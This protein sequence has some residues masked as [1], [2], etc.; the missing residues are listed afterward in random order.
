MKKKLQLLLTCAFCAAFWLAQSQNNTFRVQFSVVDATCYN[1]GK[2][3][4]GLENDAGELLDSVPAGLS[5][6]RIYYKQNLSDSV[7]YSGTY[8]SGGSDT[9]NLNYGTYT[10]GVEALK[11]DGSNGFVR[12]DTQTV[13]T[14][15]TSY[16]RPTASTVPFDAWS[17]LTDA[18][19]LF[20]IPCMDIGR[21]QLHIENGTLP[22]TITV[23][24]NDSGD[25]LRHEIF[26]HRPYDGNDPEKYNYKDYFSID[27]L[28]GGN[29]GF[30]VVDGCGYGLPRMNQEVVVKHFPTP[31]CYNIWS[32]SGNMADSN[33]IKINIQFNYTEILGLHNLMHQY[34][35]YRF[36]YGDL[37]AS[38][39]KMMPAS[40]EQNPEY[41][42][43]DTIDV[44][45][46]Y[47]DIWD[48]GIR[49]EYKVEGCG[50][51]NSSIDYYFRKPNDQ[52]FIKKHTDITDSVSNEAHG[53]RRIAYWHHDNY[54]IRYYSNKFSP[55]YFLNYLYLSS[56]SHEYY[57]YYFTHPI[58]WIYT[59]T[60]SGEIVK[61]DSI[62]SIVT[63]SVITLEEINNLYGV[64]DS[65]HV[66]PMERKLVDSKGC[67]LYSSIDT[68]NFSKNRHCSEVEW[69]IKTVSNNNDHCCQEPRSVVV[70]TTNKLSYDHDS[71][72]V[73][74]V[75]S[76]YNNLY[77]FEAVYLQRE[78]RWEIRKDS[79]NNPA[80]V[81]GSRGGCDLAISD[82]CLPS[83]P[84]E[85]EI[86]S[87]CGSH[88]LSKKVQFP[89]HYEMRA[90]HNGPPTV[91]RDCNNFKVTYDSGSFHRWQQNTSPENGLPL[92]PVVEEL[93]MTVDV[94]E[95][96]DLQ[97]ANKQFKGELP[98]SIDLSMPGTYILHS[99]PLDMDN[100]CE[101]NA[102]RYDTIVID[103]STVEFVDVRA[104]LCD[105][106]S[107][108][109]NV[110]VQST[111]GTKPY[112]YT[113]Y[114]QPNKTGNILG[115]NNSGVF[116]NVPMRSHQT[117]S[118]FVQDSCNAYFHI[119]F[120]PSTVANLQKVWF[121]GQLSATSACEG[122]I[123]QA[124][125][126]ALEGTI[127]YEWS[128]PEGFSATT[129]DPYIL[130]PHSYTNGWY[131]V[132]L[133]QPQCDIELTDSIFLTILEA[134]GIMLS[135]DTTVCPSESI[136]LRFTPH[137]SNNSDLIHFAI[138]FENANSNEVREYA[139]PSGVTV[140]DTFITRSP[141]KIYPLHIDD[142]VCQSH[143]THY[144]TTHIFLRTDLTPNCGTL[145][146]WDTV[147]RGSDAR[148]SAHAMLE[149]PFTLNWY[150]D[151]ALTKLLKSELVSDTNQW[152]VYDTSGIMRKTILYISLQKG[153]ACPSANGIITNTIR[154]QEGSTS[155]SCGEGCRLLDSRMADS[156]ANMSEDIVHRFSSSDST[157][158]CITFDQ[159]NL[160]PTA[161][162]QIF[163]GEEL[164]PDSLLGEI[165]CGSQP[166]CHFVSDGNTL[167]LH[168]FG[169]D[170]RSTDWSAIVESA[171]GI[172]IADVKMGK[173]QFL[174]D[175][176]CQ[177][178][179][180]LYEDRHHITP[181]LVSAAEANLAIR[182]AGNYYYQQTYP[183][184]SSNNCDS[185]VYFTLTVS[186][187]PITE[188]VATITQQDGFLW[189][190]SLYREGGRH[191]F[192]STSPD[193]CDKLEILTLKVLD[194][195]CS[196]GEI[197]IGDTIPLSISAALTKASSQ[198]NLTSRNAKVG[199]I[200]CDDGSILSVDSFFL[201]G[202][203]P[204]GVVFYVDRTGI[205]GRALALSEVRGIM[206]P[207]P[208]FNVLVELFNY[209]TSVRDL[210]GWQNTCNLLMTN[211][212]LHPANNV[213]D[214]DA[215][216]YCYYYNHVTQTA[217]LLPHGWYLPASGEMF[218][219][220]SNMM[221][222][223]QSLS[224]MNHFNNIYQKMNSH[225]YWSSTISASDLCI[226]F[227]KGNVKNDHPYA[228]KG[229][230]PVIRF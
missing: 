227:S 77:N 68:L 103:N 52:Y 36:V 11:D 91:T 118:C 44:I 123:I 214:L 59:D 86:N 16:Q 60:R 74:L 69:F 57:R 71:T 5:N 146:T 196:N 205:H 166:L 6:V 64:S 153:D 167:T 115:I 128:G 83:G 185:A 134:P 178:S 121:D 89:N 49:L 99:G 48:L 120:Q 140:T 195:S 78:Q 207:N 72:I 29:W 149:P 7:Q 164:N 62:P 21:V 148:L 151:Y 174:E 19:N 116:L 170:T 13:L 208:L 175:E 126:L 47:C 217:D 179:R 161:H 159:L 143:A 41:N 75:R 168:F 42:L 18:G 95:T 220:F 84:Y 46:K 30:Y 145:T 230:R 88:T 176:V 76:P 9:L 162:L 54:S 211:Q 102:E 202:K 27:S 177:S 117:L 96:P 1:N 201:S 155:L 206:S 66:I 156:I 144:D 216:S 213:S 218:L 87:F 187:P 31:M 51:A 215:L 15:N 38:E 65:G 188:T 92:E 32:S 122:A 112:T 63:P 229:I 186:P 129:A 138:A 34:A 56:K 198:N 181:A 125:A 43:F 35:K 45:N 82:Y 22:Y 131:K 199:D 2:V 165:N 23:V 67:I 61:R 157:R 97:F 39:W 190:D 133:R 58:T 221:E 158:L 10:V 200:L 141:A 163:T 152:S 212:E 160:N 40:T 17:R 171:P 37:G 106:S 169:T 203:A 136:P 85:F 127:Q 113:L 28:P 193:G 224:K 139:A 147:C 104:I 107:T 189:H 194:V 183:N 172:A 108:T 101:G 173:V 114:D 26:E 184:G 180:N 33:V 219:L 142:G 111:N 119:N 222:V 80:A 226:S 150:G 135:P 20:T 182:K 192:L 8:Y 124:H 110:W 228:I 137:S 109:G 81:L 90:E 204:K 70:Y 12:V 132:T 209:E 3:I 14:V 4:Y 25:T 100:I 191:V 93:A 210:D 53:C 105:T 73:R 24:N 223:N 197:C 225:D 130:V 154:M 55:S 50:T 98:L 94:I 79:L